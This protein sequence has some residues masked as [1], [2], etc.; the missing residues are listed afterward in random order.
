M[1]EFERR[2]KFLIIR[3]EGVRERQK[4][5][6]E[7]ERKLKGCGENEEMKRIRIKRNSW[8]SLGK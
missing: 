7:K 5:F 8:Q 1:R 4:A 6:V 3:D 2:R